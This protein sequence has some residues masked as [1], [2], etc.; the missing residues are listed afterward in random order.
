M[1]RGDLI[2]PKNATAKKE[3]VVLQPDEIRELFSDPTYPRYNRNV[4][5]HFAYAWRFLVV[6][7]LR[8]GELCRI[9]AGDIEGRTLTIK[10]SINSSNEIT[11]GKNKNARR[12]IELTEIAMKVLSDQREML[13]RKN[14]ISPWVFCNASGDRPNPNN[15]Y[16][17][18]DTYR[19]HH[20]IRSSLHELRHTFISVNKSDLPLELMKS[21]VGHSKSMDTFGVYGHEIEGDRHRAAAII[22]DVFERILKQNGRKSGWKDFPEKENSR[23]FSIY[24]KKRLKCIMEPRGVEPLSEDRT[25]EAS[26]SAVHVLTFPLPGSHEQDRGFSSFIKSRAPQSLGALVPCYSDAAGLR[27]RRLRGDVSQLSCESYVFVV[28][29]SF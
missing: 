16:D 3:K 27:R 17:Q 6:T 26:P 21:V 5:A 7:G 9:R 25:N 4:E 23:F 28:V 24:R 14:L 2:I 12:T 10:R 8:R 15:V 13:K 1:E 29:S 22:E 18:W 11:E 20:G 19:K